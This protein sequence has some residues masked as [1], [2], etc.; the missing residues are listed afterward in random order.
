MTIETAPPQ[1][2]TVRL[3]IQKF[4]EISRLFDTL[5]GCQRDLFLKGMEKYLDV[6]ND[7]V[8][9]MRLE[10]LA[11]GATAILGGVAG[12]ASAFIPAAGTDKIFGQFDP[13]F[14]K[15][16]LKVI[17]KVAP[18]VGNT[19]QGLLHGETTKKNA[20]R[21][22]LNGATIPG[23]QQFTAEMRKTQQTFAENISTLQRT[24]KAAS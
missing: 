10:A 14:V 12:G 6:T 19:G 15:S 16:A 11:T 24:A 22:L 1:H 7:E 8:F 17:T 13:A 2:A 21:T 23:A 18:Q 3:L 20:A 5:Q 4:S 9:W